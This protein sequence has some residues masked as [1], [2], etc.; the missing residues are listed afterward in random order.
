[1]ETKLL[2]LAACAVLALAIIVIVVRMRKQ[3]M[4]DPRQYTPLDAVLTQPAQCGATALLVKPVNGAAS[5]DYLRALERAIAAA[6]GAPLAVAAGRGEQL[7]GVT[8][9]P[10][11]LSLVQGGT[12][13]RIP[14]SLVCSSAGVAPA[15]TVVTTVD[16]QFGPD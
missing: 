10:L 12:V 16:Y 11:G 1:M 8:R 13:V 4:D 14:I 6:G 7:I 15:G 5:V 3:D 9:R 2:I